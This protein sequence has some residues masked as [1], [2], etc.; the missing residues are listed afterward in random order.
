MII[1]GIIYHVDVNSAFLSWEA[2]YRLY[3]LGAKLDLR[4]VP[5]A[6]SGDQEKRHG[7]ILAKSIPC[8]QYG[9]QTGEPVTDAKRKLNAMKET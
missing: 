3:H 8:K 5:S 6:V 2:T 9:V 1:G 7:I 4:T